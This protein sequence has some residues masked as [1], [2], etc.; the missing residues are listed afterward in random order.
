MTDEKDRPIAPRKSGRN[1]DDT[2]ASGNSEKPKGSRDKAT[3]VAL[4]LLNGEVG[5]LFLPALRTGQSACISILN[6]GLFWLRAM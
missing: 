4:S 1:T 3:Q 5:T 2:F 6:G